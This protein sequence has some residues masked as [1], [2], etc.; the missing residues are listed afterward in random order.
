[1]AGD[2]SAPYWSVIWDGD[3]AFL[4]D[5]AGTALVDGDGG[6]LHIVRELTVTAGYFD[7]EAI[8]LDPATGA[9]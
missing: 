5:D 7:R 4:A 6:R 9:N 2:S 8:L 3:R 1:M